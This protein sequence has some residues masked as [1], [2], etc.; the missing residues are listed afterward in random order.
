MQRF[1]CCLLAGLLGGLPCLPAGAQA[2]PAG[3]WP[4][5]QWESSAPEEQGMD[6]RA[7]AALVDFGAANEMDSL[8]VT[9]H[10]KLVAEAYYAPF[11]AGLRHRINSATKG[12]VAALTGIAIEQGRLKGTDQP[13]MELFADRA[14]ANLDERKKAM[15]VQHLLDM[16]SGLDWTEPLSDA[17]PRSLIEL[18]R[19][20]NWV[21]YV[22]DRPMAQAPGTGF[23]YNSGGPHLLTAILARQTGMDVQDFAARH[24]FKPLGISD[25]RWR[26]DPQGIATGGLGLYL[27][28]RDMAKLGYLYLRGGEWEGAQVVPR[29][30]VERVYQA[31]VPMNLSAAADWRYGDLWWT[32]PLRKAYMAVGYNRQIILVMPQLGLVAAMT[33]RKNYPFGA[34]FDLMAQA[35]KS[36]QPLPPN[37]EAAAL[38]ARRIADVA[39][40]KPSAA[41]AAPALAERISGKTYRLAPNE[42]GIKELTL[43][44]S[45]QPS[46]DI[47]SYAARGSSETKTTTR[48]LGMDGRFSRLDPAAGDLVVS[49]AS[50]TGPDTLSVTERWLEEAG[51]GNYVLQFTGSKVAI[52]YTDGLG[53]G[54]SLTG[55]ASN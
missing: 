10:G 14:I 41:A 6:S 8:V 22:L 52:R 23:N 19:S 16:T 3:P 30:W 31:R 39:D 44:L 48:P 51:T 2:Q 34:L 13:V 7:L 45:G 9:R 11:R 4:T 27:Q 40:E 46:Y 36:D 35:A 18:E 33:G 32:F 53:R 15:T 25:I 29:R 37:P 12:V 24:L 28:T 50:W 5:Q 20:A 43:H 26:H 17:P 47:V 1:T 55:E 49:K 54:G 21:Q 38:L 42:L